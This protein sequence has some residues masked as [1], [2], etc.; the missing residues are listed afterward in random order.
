RRFRERHGGE[1]LG[2]HVEARGGAAHA[3]GLGFWLPLAWDV[4]VTAIQVRLSRRRPA[5]AEPASML[6]GTVRH[7]RH[8]VRALLRSPGFTATA[9]L[10]LT[11]GIGADTAL[12]SVVY[13]VLVRPL[14]YPAGERLVWVA[15][16][17]M[18]GENLGRW[19]AGIPSFQ[20]LE[21]FGL[22]SFTWQ[23][24]DGARRLRGMAVTHG[25]LPLL[26][27]RPIRGR[28]WSAEEGAAARTPVV[29][30]GRRFWREALGGRDPEGLVIRLD[31]TTYDV[32][33][34][35]PADFHNLGYD[36]DLWLPLDQQPT[37]AGLNGVGLLAPRRTLA[38]AR[39]EAR[40]LL[41]RLDPTTLS[42]AAGGF[43]NL[44]GFREIF[45]GDV[46][47][48]L[49]ILFGAA[50]LVLLL[51]CANVA[52]LLLTRATGRTR[53]MAI[54]AALGAGRRTL[55]AQLL[56]ESALLA[57]A[58]AVLGLLLAWGLVHRVADLAP[59]Y[60]F[61]RSVTEAVRIDVSVLAFTLGAATLTVLVAGLAPALAAARSTARGSS[62]VGRSTADPSSHR[63][64]EG[65][66]AAQVALAFVLL[67][68]T[69]LMVR[70]WLVLRPAHPG[71]E[72]AD[73]LVAGLSLPDDP[74]AN[75]SFV[76]RLVRQIQLGTPGVRAAAVTDVPLS[77]MITTTR[78]LAVDGEALPEGEGRPLSVDLRSATP[79]YLDVVGMRMVTGRALLDSDGPDAPFA[80]VVNESAA[81][82]LWPDLAGVVGRRVTLDLYEDTADFTVV[83]RVADARSTGATTRARPEVFASYDQVPW[84]RLHLVV[85]A[86]GSAGIDA[87]VL[88]RAVAE[89]DP[90]IPVEDVT[91]LEAI[92]S[93]SVARRRYQAA[94]MAAFGL[95]A[96]LLSAVG[97]YG[98]LAH[99]VGRRTREIGIRMALGARRG[100]IILRVVRRGAVP[101]AGGLAA[102]TAL[103][104]A[105][106]KVL[107]SALY[108]VS[109]T[110][111][112]SFLAAALVLGAVSLVAAW[113]P[114]RRAAAVD[115]VQ[116]LA[117][118]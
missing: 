84:R 17:A 44:N 68:G 60:Y 76:Q 5:T 90:S 92:A 61:G 67:V 72:T 35:L 82:R 113:L 115:P 63:W 88:R 39:T 93:D 66:V 58:G 4:V 30:V 42:R 48:P 109:R 81:R 79:G 80:L 34:V 16:P 40:A 85:H 33:G 12:F 43:A 95:L 45:T 111:P 71:F 8:G 56:V 105:G 25:F 29:V 91:S 86:P 118:E 75:R 18:T 13:G 6:D 47:T 98:V 37:R 19:R 31:D 96:L 21:A 3:G 108:G 57:L 94:L 89:L 46:R 24:S 59:R 10:T 41:T 102:G 22:R 55:A 103:A 62:L 117:A 78:V 26:G 70:T 7:L 38:A 69:A 15:T 52:N 97:C 107:E 110:D 112:T 20:R 51:A 23:A 74:G 101:V 36:I 27:A 87:G 83:G 116:S 106:T 2:H 32:L 114:A 14:P 50:G 9:V 64:R 100:G 53:E 73:R 104:L 11:L 28:L 49:L 65:L 99:A 77:G 54:R 1:L